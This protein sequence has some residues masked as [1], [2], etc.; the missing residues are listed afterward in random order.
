[1]YWQRRRQRHPR[2]AALKQLSAD[3]SGC[4]ANDPAHLAQARALDQ[5]AAL[6]RAFRAAQCRVAHWP[7]GSADGAAC[8]AHGACEGCLDAAR[9]LGAVAAPELT[10]NDAHD[11]RGRYMRAL[12]VAKPTSTVR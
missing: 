6:S 2:W 11:M 8:E 4:V 9:V 7:A 12:K 10:G 3:S 1:L 5:A